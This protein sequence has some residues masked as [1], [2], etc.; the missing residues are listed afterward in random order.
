MRNRVIAVVVVILVG[1]GAWY[2]WMQKEAAPV[3]APATSDSAQATTNM[4]PNGRDY[5]PG[6]LLLGTDVKAGLGTYLIASNGMTLYRYTKDTK[7]VSN[8]TGQCAVNWPPYALPS[9]N[10]LGNLQA[11]VNGDVGSLKRADGSMQVTYDGQPLYFYAK[12]T[13]SGSTTG[14]GVGGVWFVVK[15]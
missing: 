11:G 2:F 12:D 6:N 4:N 3:P 15:P 14:E 10:F 9:G 8:C 7:G 13:A 1:L 5:S